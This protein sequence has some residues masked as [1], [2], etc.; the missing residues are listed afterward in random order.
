M[1]V[2]QM[3]TFLLGGKIGISCHAVQ[4]KAHCQ[5]VHMTFWLPIWQSKWKSWSSTQYIWSVYVA[6]YLTHGCVDLRQN[7]GE[8]NLK[9]REHE[10]ISIGYSRTL[11]WHWCWCSHYVLKIFC[12]TTF[13][14]ERDQFPLLLTCISSCSALRAWFKCDVWK[15]MLEVSHGFSKE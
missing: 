12:S 2:I 9:E 10:Q 14:R 3:W 8:Q 7:L 5:N 1:S 6:L 4:Q 11:G 13:Y 15:G